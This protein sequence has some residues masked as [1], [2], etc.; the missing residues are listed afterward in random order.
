MFIDEATIE[1]KAGTGGNG[2]HAYE[3]QPFKPKGH[4]DGGNGGRGGHIYMIGNAQAHTLQDTAFRRHY[5]AERGMHG[6]GSNK[7]GKNG[8]DI[9][10]PVALGTVI[11]DA[12]TNQII[13]DCVEEGKL[14]LVAKGGRGGRGN[15]SLVTRSNRKDRKS[16]R[17]NSSHW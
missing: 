16:T 3:R 12:G 17:L 13:A 9:I 6:K 10:L 5:K 8:E 1:V 15:A 7:T 4:P 14:I 2:C 11:Y